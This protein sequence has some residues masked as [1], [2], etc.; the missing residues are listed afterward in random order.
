MGLGEEAEEVGKVGVFLF[1]FGF[2][3]LF[4]GGGVGADSGF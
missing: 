3:V 4:V 1:C 2:V